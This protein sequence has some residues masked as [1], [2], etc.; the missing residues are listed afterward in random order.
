MSRLKRQSAVVRVA[1]QTRSREQQVDAELV[2][3]RV[4][5]ER[6]PLGHVVDAVPPVREEGDV[7]IMPVVE[8]VLVVERRLILKEEVRIRRVR[9]T[10]QHHETVTL[11][12][13]EAVIT[14]TP[15]E[16][17]ATGAAPP[18]DQPE[19]FNA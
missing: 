3:E 8:E 11:R 13:Q 4:E 2:R 9:S 12:E 6:I 7:T 18:A 1:T 16:A 10:E 19:A 5:I 17:S 15:I 14:R